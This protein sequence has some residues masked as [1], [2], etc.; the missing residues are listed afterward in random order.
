MKR[1]AR[2]SQ[3]F[4]AQPN[5]L[6]TVFFVIGLG[7][8]LFNAVLNYSTYYGVGGGFLI[9]LGFALSVLIDRN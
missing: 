4:G 5:I 7:M 1:T 2:Q 9:A 6:A 8:M 3:I